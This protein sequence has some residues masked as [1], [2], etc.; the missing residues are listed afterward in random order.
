MKMKKLQLIISLLCTNIIFAQSKHFFYEYISIPDSTDK[1]NVKSEILVLS[2]NKDK[3]EFYSLEKFKND[4]IYAVNSRKPNLLAAPE[5]PQKRSNWN[6]VTKFANKDDIE[7]VS[8]IF[9][10]VYLVSQKINL[11]WHLENNFDTILGYRVQNA[12]TDF[13]GRKWSAWFAKEIP[14][15]D[16]PYKFRG[17]PGLILKIEDVSKS[18]IYE[19]KA[20]KNLDYLFEYPVMNEEQLIKIPYSKYVTIFKNSRKNPAGNLVKDVPDYTDGNGKIVS[21]DKFRREIEKNS[22]ERILRDNNILE[23]GLLK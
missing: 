22:R 18:H 4:S 3:S 1:K 10:D 12:T 15:Q 16:G 5:P 20:I 14:I 21:Q 9:R 2:T 19:L 17:L 7:F 23:L 6:R 13:A 8:S 11:K